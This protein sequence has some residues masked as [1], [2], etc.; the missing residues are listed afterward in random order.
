[1]RMRII[2]TALHDGWVKHTGD[3]GGLYELVNT[4]TS[5]QVVALL[6]A[7]L[8]TKKMGAV[9]YIGNTEDIAGLVSYLVS[10]E[11]RYIT[12]M[13]LLRPIP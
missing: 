4:S 9:G 2:V 13:R 7:E 5:V 11:A 1:M 10:P 12:G 6:P 3:E 8:Q